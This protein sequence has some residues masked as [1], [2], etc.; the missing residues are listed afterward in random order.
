MTCLGL[1]H[2]TISFSRIHVYHRLPRH[3]QTFSMC[4]FMHQYTIPFNQYQGKGSHPGLILSWV[5]VPRTLESTLSCMI[6][7]SCDPFMYTL[8]R[9]STGRVSYHILR[10][11]FYYAL[12]DTITSN[13]HCSSRERHIY[14]LLY[15]SLLRS[16][17]FVNPVPANLPNREAF[18]RLRIQCRL[19]LGG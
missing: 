9:N 19:Q 13:I 7:L 6:F 16:R 3:A 11:L 4:F 1:V 2:A 5:K 18:H 15:H 12:S 17:P 10:Y 8:V 14:N